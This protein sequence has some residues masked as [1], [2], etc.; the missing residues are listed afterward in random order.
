MRLNYVLKNFII[1][2]SHRIKVLSFN[3]Y[4]YGNDFINKDKGLLLD[5][6]SLNIV[7][8]VL[9]AYFFANGKNISLFEQ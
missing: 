6:W 7:L 9:Y 2:F 8:Y 3:P 1:C 5:Y 4:R